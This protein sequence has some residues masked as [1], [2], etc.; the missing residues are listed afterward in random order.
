MKEMAYLLG[1]SSLI[2][3]A[4]SGAIYSWAQAVLDIAQS[5]GMRSSS[6]QTLRRNGHELDLDD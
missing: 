3:A 6:L 2:F 4:S 5:A 1:R